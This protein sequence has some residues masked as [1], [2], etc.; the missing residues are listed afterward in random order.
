M[1]DMT[2]DLSVIILT[3]NEGIHIRR[4]I[5]N[6]R[7]MA[8]RI[9][10]VDS[11]S[12]D[13][14]VAIA[15]GLGADV[16]QNKWENNHAWQFNWALANLPIPPGWVLRLDADE[17]LSDELLGEIQDKLP[18]MPS[19]VSGIVFKRRH[20]FMGQWVKRG[21][22]PVKLLRLFRSGKGRCEQR[23]MD[24]HLQVTEGVTVEFEHDFV[25][26]NLNPLGWWIAKHNGYAIR[27]AIDLLDTELGLLPME[28]AQQGV[29]S[30]QAQAKRKK[31]L[32]YA[33]APLFW[34]AFAYFLYR[35][36]LRLGFTEGKVGFLWHFLQGWWYRTLVDAKIFEIKKE[37]GNDKE[38]MVAY[39]KE[40]YGINVM[41]NR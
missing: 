3:Y 28:H 40:K 17:Y 6:A 19:H 32:K 10:V 30:K 36:F 2:L 21:V 16:Y 11:F 8:T 18:G 25:D 31:K 12:S 41:M 38:K 14:T 39:V 37:C 26:D 23:W 33:R 24:E 1:S 13:D 4:C 22:Y 5:E 9:F 29:L 7:R 15:K 35:Y 20:L 27:E 34:R